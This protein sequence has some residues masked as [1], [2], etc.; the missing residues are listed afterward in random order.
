MEATALNQEG[1]LQG[2]LDVLLVGAWEVQP[3][4]PPT[5]PMR[6]ALEWRAPKADRIAFTPAPTGAPCTALADRKSHEDASRARSA[7]LHIQ[8]LGVAGLRLALERPRIAYVGEIPTELRR[9]QRSAGQIWLATLTRDG[10]EVKVLDTAAL[11]VP[12][13]HPRREAM[14]ARCCYTQLIYLKDLPVALAVE[15]ADEEVVLPLEQVHWR[16]ERGAYPWLAATLPSFGYAL[17]DPAGLPA[18]GA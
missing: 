9:V 5:E 16:G 3:E 17:V 15:N 13:N 7:F 4:A 12:A 18:A 11:V 6:P 1:V 14:L 2:Y 8:P 10:H